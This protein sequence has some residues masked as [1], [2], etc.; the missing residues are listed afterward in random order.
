MGRLHGSETGGEHVSVLI[1]LVSGW[2]SFCG[3]LS[4]PLVWGLLQQLVE[5]SQTRISS[6]SSDSSPVLVA[7][8]ASEA[9][10]VL[11]PA[12]GTCSALGLQQEHVSALCFGIPSSLS[13]SPLS[14]CVNRKKLSQETL[15]VIGLRPGLLVVSPR[16][17]FMVGRL[18]TRVDS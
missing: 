15:R 12:L 4:R 7:T 11:V 5:G 10:A 3:R 2:E 1:L 13:L 9:L 16:L 17:E 18:D 6:S 8:V 14:T